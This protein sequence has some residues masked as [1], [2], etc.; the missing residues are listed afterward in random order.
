MR[1]PTCEAPH[2]ALARGGAKKTQSSL[3]YC[4]SLP[5]TISWPF[6]LR[7]IE[8]IYCEV[9]LGDDELKFSGEGY[10]TSTVILINLTYLLTDLLTY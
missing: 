3:Y 6:I 10:K 1:Y 4:Y 5:P 7:A 8:K 2:L 9:Q